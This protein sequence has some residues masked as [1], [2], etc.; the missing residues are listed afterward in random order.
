[1]FQGCNCFIGIVAG[2]EPVPVL[3]V[4]VPCLSDEQPVIGGAWHAPETG[5]V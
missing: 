4:R 3:P 1:M 5:G 2:P